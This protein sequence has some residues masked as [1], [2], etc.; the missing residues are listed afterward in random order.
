MDN[1]SWHKWTEIENLETEKRKNSSSF[2]MATNHSDIEWV[3]TE[4]IDGTNIGLNIFS[5]NYIFNSR[6]N[7]L[8]PLSSF[9]NIYA[10]DS[11]VKPLIIKLQEYFFSTINSISQV[12][13]YGEYFGKK[14]MN[15]IDYKIDYDFRFFSM[16]IISND[17]AGEGL[18]KKVL[19]FKEFEDVMKS[20]GMEKFIIPVLGV[21]D[22]FED[23][24]NYPN[25]K[26]STFNESATMEGVV[27]QSYN[28]PY[29]IFDRCSLIFKNKNKAFEER[30][31]RGHKIPSEI[32]VDEI[33]RIKS[34]KERFKEYCNK[35]RMYSVISKMYKPTSEKEYSKF[36][37]PFLEDAYKD[38]CK[39]YPDIKLTD[40]EKKF[41]TNIG[42]DGFMIFSIIVDELNKNS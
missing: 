18:Y 13:L 35:S 36:V 26:P 39:D 42:G 9:Y 33:K 20:I 8:G 28:Y 38:F 32:P 21:Y 11:I 23:A 16:H 4:K 41:V 29:T 1:I 12:I 17:L 3:V 19:S 7:L 14:I 30:T 6:N 25:D 5:D 40:K 24:M 31:S 22:N 34:I 15:R 37:G 10:N 27:I 2:F